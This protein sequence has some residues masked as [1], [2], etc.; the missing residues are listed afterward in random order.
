MDH[1]I[2]LNKLKKLR[3]TGKLANWIK[4]FLT[5]RTQTVIVNGV[6]SF[7]A[8]VVSGVPQ[9]TVL[10]P[11]LFLLMISDIDN[12]I[13]FSHL[14]SFADDTRVLK[15]INGLIDTFKLQHDLNNVYSWTKNNNMSLNSC[16]FEHLKYGKDNDTKKLS[17]YL[18]NDNT[19]IKNKEFVKDLGVLMSQDCSFSEHINK[20]ITKTKDISSWILR[21][22]ATR[23][24]HIMLTLWKALVLPHFDYCSQLWSPSSILHIQELESIQRSFLKKIK[25]LNSMNYWK[26]LKCINMYSLQRRRERYRIIY[27][28][29]ILEGIVPNFN[30][31]EKTT[32]IGGITSY[33]TYRHGRKCRIRTVE[34]SSFRNEICQSLAVQGPKLF[35][36]L[37]QHLR[38]ITNC[39]KI[40]FKAALDKYLEKIP[41]EPHIIGIREVRHADSNSLV[42]QIRCIG[43]NALDG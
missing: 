34:R 24:K 2:L 26:Q 4:S 14:A 5:N 20:V 32:E 11:I 27:V 12:D 16:K 9:G 7:A 43:R 37:P 1:T 18:T 21:T 40:K 22:F 38:N 8:S 28:W 33:N 31:V 41:D 23:D 19:V 3:I 42:D 25:G 35:N 29:S 13:K 36:S 30:H 10:G 15:E 17:V 39:S 6:K